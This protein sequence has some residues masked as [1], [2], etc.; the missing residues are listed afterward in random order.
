MKAGKSTE[1]PEALTSPEEGPQE[2]II[3]QEVLGMVRRMVGELPKQQG[4]AVIM[5]YFEGKSYS[6]VGEGLQCSE[7][8]ARAHVS[9]AIARLRK[10]LSQ[11]FEKQRS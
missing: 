10:D 6:E 11:L 2:Q 4:K 5:R 7:S 3:R 8:G 1:S 9:K